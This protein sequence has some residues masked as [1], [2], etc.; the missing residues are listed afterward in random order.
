VRRSAFS[1]AGGF[2]SF[3]L[4]RATSNEDVDLALKLR[5]HGKLLFCPRARMAHHQEASGRLSP[6]HVAEDDLYN[7]Y[8]I[9][10]HTIGLGRTRA[11]A[12][13]AIY[14]AIETASN[15]A[16]ALWRGRGAHVWTLAGGRLR[17]LA[18]IVTNWGP[19]IRAD[20]KP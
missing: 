20:S 14:F 5:R 7:R 19:E 2:S 13:I 12:Q 17:A 9:L 15:L 16:G 18:R 3:F 4:R 6:L 8:L 11:L 1:A 10:R